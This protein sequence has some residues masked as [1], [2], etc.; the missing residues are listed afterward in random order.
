MR[1]TKCEDDSDDSPPD[2]PGRWPLVDGPCPEADVDADASESFDRPGYTKLAIGVSVRPY[3]TDRT[4]ITH[5]ARSATV[6]KSSRRCFR[7]YWALTGPFAGCLMG[8]V[9]DTVTA[10]H[11]RTTIAVE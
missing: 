7:R 1:C 9:L 10:D 11:E 3:D 4:L 8:T 6:D 5:E 2:E